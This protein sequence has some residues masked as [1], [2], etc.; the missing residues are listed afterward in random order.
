MKGLGP[1]YQEDYDK[2]LSIAK[3]NDAGS[4]TLSFA[5]SAAGVLMTWNNIPDSGYGT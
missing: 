2:Q 5:P 4:Q 1:I 3:A